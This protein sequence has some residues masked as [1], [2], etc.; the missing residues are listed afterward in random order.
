RIGKSPL[1]KVT[2]A[3]Q[4]FRVALRPQPVYAPTSLQPLV[5]FSLALE[6]LDALNF[7]TGA[8]SLD[9]PVALCDALVFEDDPRRFT[10]EHQYVVVRVVA[11]GAPIESGRLQP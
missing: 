7:G 8:M 11:I 5:N 10:H 3:A 2:A 6:S 4:S 1:Q 9:L